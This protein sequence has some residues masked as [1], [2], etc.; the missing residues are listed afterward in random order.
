[1]EDGTAAAVV[2]GGEYLFSRT[3]GVVTLRILILVNV[4]GRVCVRLLVVVSYAV[5]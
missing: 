4:Y 5:L 2:E 3:Y 1:M